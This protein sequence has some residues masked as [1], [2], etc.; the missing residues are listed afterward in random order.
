MS[1]G[2]LEGGYGVLCGRGLEV[3][4]RPEGVP[5]PSVADVQRP[6]VLL[7]MVGIRVTHAVDP[8]G[9]WDGVYHNVGDWEEGVREGGRE[10]GRIERGEDG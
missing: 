7:P 6:L 3:L 9:V 1:S 2:S 10:G 5:Q 4:R 8:W